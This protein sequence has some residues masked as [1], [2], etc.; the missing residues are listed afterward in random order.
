MQ[1]LNSH[2]KI[3]LSDEFFLYKSPS[4]QCWFP[5]MHKGLN[6]LVNRGEWPER[7]AAIMRAVWYLTSTPAVVEDGL[8][9]R[10]WGN[11]TPGSENYLDFY[12]S[13]FEWCPPRYIYALRDPRKVFLSVRNMTWGRHANIDGQ[14]RKYC[15]SVLQMEQFKANHPERIFVCQV[16][17]IGDDENERLESIREVFAF[18]DE[19]VTDE[20]D[21]FTK[22]WREVHSNETVRRKTPEGV[23]TELST[24]DLKAIEKNDRIQ[25][26]MSRY[27]YRDIQ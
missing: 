15:E 9:C 17:Q 21:L 16:D 26:I 10:R 23:M 13:V 4:V 8:K 14:I 19:S 7:K 22:K 12:E 24:A 1:L 5:E 2:P 11:K 18:V 3:A 20:V 27:G 25:N 6:D